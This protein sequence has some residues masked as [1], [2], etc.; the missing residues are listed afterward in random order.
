MILAKH[1]LVVT[2]LFLLCL[3]YLFMVFF[4]K[5]SS[6]EE[7]QEVINEEKNERE[8][9]ESANV[10]YTRQKNVIYKYLIV[11]VVNFLVAFF[12]FSGLVISSLFYDGSDATKEYNLFLSV[13]VA[14]SAYVTFLEFKL[15][16][17]KSKKFLY[18]T[19]ALVLFPLFSAIAQMLF[20]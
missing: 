8:E 3:Y 9:G 2:I 5:K 11:L 16:A 10:P 18:P 1:P 15:I 14:L 20:L 13:L 4:Y 17:K 6:K 12:Y 19:I 7:I